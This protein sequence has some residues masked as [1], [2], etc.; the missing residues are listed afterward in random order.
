[1]SDEIR[2]PCPEYA[3]PAGVQHY[4]CEHE[5]LQQGCRLGFCQAE[6]GAALVLL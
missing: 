3:T 5:W 6:A 2:L 4:V 1:M